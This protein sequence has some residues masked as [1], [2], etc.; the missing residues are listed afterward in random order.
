MKSWIIISWLVWLSI[1]PV[2]GQNR[3][4]DFRQKEWKEVLE[5]ARNA[6]R[7]VFLDGYTAW[8]GPCKI[9][10]KEVFT[11][12]SVADFFNRNFVS[13]KLDME[14]EGKVLA[15]KYQITSYPTLLFIDP[16]TEQRVHAL[17]G[18]VKAEVLIQAGK[19]AMNQ[20]NSLAG[21]EKR[22]Q[23]GEREVGFMNRYLT[24][25]KAAAK[26][27]ERQIVLETYIRA[28]TDKQFVSKEVWDILNGQWDAFSDPFTYEFQRFVSLRKDFYKVAE[29]E[30]VDFKIDVVVRNYMARYIR[31]DRT[32][33]VP[34]DFDGCR[35]LI[36]WLQTVDYPGGPVWLAQLFTA[37]YLGKE[38]YRGMIESMKDALKFHFM[39]ADTESFYLI[40]FLRP[41]LDCSDSGLLK[42][43]DSW[44]GEWLEKHSGY[45]LLENIKA[46]LEKK[47]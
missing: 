9:L 6:H 8:C 17:V 1:S 29:P 15:E 3:S 30:K 27:K 39:D 14:K 5:Q 37:E 31:W 33:G 42:E 21:L 28:L 22:Y 38:D 4:I 23:A 24:A 47:L 20:Q 35:H 34:F 19:D 43:V 44:L 13:I 11:Q 7:L 12:D 18:N 40:L 16:E 41:F 45:E 25:L 36:D 26:G 10:A 46:G 32:R 2:A